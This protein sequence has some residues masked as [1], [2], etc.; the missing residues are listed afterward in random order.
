MEVT[1]TTRPQWTVIEM[2][3]DENGWDD[4]ALLLDSFW[5]EA[6]ALGERDRLAALNRDESTYYSVVENEITVVYPSDELPPW[7]PDLDRLKKRGYDGQ[8]TD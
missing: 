8:P 4:G 5:S 3:R 7:M 1:R 2:T 6:D